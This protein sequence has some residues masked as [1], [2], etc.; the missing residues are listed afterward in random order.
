MAR[1]D[2]LHMGNTEFYSKQSVF[3]KKKITCR[4]FL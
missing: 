1:T 3:Q 4:Y 2:R